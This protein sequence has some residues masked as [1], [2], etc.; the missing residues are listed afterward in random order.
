[1]TRGMFACSADPIHDGHI[2]I[3]ER[4]AKNYDEFVL[5]IGLN[6]EKKHLFSLE[7][8]LDM[9]RRATSHIKNV[10]VVAFRGL[11]VDYAWEQMIPEVVKS[12]RNEADREYERTLEVAG[13]TQKLGIRTKLLD[14]NPELAHISSTIVKGLKKEQG[15]VHDLVPLCVNQC[16][17]ARMLGQYAVGVTGEIGAGKSYVSRK[18]EE[19]GKQKGIP[20]YNIDL[21]YIPHKIYD[22]T[23]KEPVYSLLRRQ[24]IE[25]FGENVGFADGTINRKALGDIVFNDAHELEKLNRMLARPIDVRLRREMYAKKGLMLINAAILAEAGMGYLCNNNVVLVGANK[26]SQERRLKERNLTTE[27]IERRLSSQYNFKKKES[28]ILKA[29]QKENN[30]N[31]WTVDNSDGSDAAQL[32]SL[33]DKIV[34]TVDV[35]GELRFRG[36]WK[37]VNADSIP[38][39]DYA[40][41][42]ETYSESYRCYHTLQHIVSGVNE[43]EGAKHLMQNPDQVL[44]A[45]FYHDFVMKQ[46]SRVDEERSAEAAYI[47]AK[48]TALLPDSFCENVKKLVMTTKHNKAPETIDEAFLIDIDLSIFGK[49]WE[50]F[51]EYERKIR[52]EYSWVPEDDFRKIR[53]GVLDKFLKRDKLYYTD[54]FRQKYESQAINNLER[55]I[56]N[57]S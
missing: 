28:E 48:K 41:L 24:I 17:D 11:L 55:S 5:G 4:A 8:R 52:D 10:K 32:E 31:I 43:F 30:G 50:E 51:S 56:A 34:R 15:F 19:I 39:A 57:L 3:V 21:D 23:V 22:G 40:K 18:L 1:M 16:L 9:A 37:R 29:I 47:V 26:E 54:F 53:K 2:D 27:Q 12:V 38:D 45:L 7:E 13:E 49:P 36:L 6:P 44:F 46:E 25:A 20:V 33:F 14:A 42:V 35:Y